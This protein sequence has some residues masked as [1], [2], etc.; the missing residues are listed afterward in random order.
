MH[1]PDSKHWGWLPP[2]SLR[3]LAELA[4]DAGNVSTLTEMMEQL[5]RPHFERVLERRGQSFAWWMEHGPH[6]EKYMVERWMAE[7]VQVYGGTAMDLA[8]HYIHVGHYKMRNG[9][10]AADPLP[11]EAWVDF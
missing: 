10:R 4:D 1:Y 5:V 3:M 8:N 6:H 7:I 9:S 2:K 11:G